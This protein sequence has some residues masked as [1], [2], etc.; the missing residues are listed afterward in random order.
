MPLQQISILD[1][2]INVQ[3][4]ILWN[5]GRRRIDLKKPIRNLFESLETEK[6]NIHYV[7]EL[8]LSKDK[9]LKR[10]QELINKGVIPILFYFVKKP[11]KNEPNN[12]P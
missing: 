10:A 1:T 2:V 9:S 3:G 6:Q 8:C 4:K 5:D 12:M 7:M 11:E